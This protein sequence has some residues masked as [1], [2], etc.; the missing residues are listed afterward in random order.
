M[1]P[2]L[3]I[4]SS[5]GLGEVAHSVQLRRES[6]VAGPV[7]VWQCRFESIMANLNLSLGGVPTEMQLISLS[8][9]AGAPRAFLIRD[10]LTAEE[11]VSLKAF[12]Q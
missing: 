6:H 11:C 12:A 1:P 10:L 4:R 5:S 3:H 9:P 2:V 7:R 8:P